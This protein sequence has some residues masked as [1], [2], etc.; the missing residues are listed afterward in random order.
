ME[1]QQ[2]FD[3]KQVRQAYRIER[4][5]EPLNEPDSASREIVYGI[6]SVYAKRADAKQLLQWN[7]RHWAVENRNHHIRDR[8]FLEDA[9]LTRTG[10]GPSNRAMC[11]NIALALIFHQNLFVS[12]PQALRHFNLNRNNTFKA[13]LSPT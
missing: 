12:V 7:R 3:F 4:Q 11:S 1:L 5:R 13:L 9:C 8:T 2:R 6:T 10:N